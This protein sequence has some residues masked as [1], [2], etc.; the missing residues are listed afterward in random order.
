MA[1]AQRQ[2]AGGFRAADLG[3]GADRDVDGDVGGAGVEQA[4]A[5]GFAEER[6]RDERGALNRITPEATLRGLAAVR[7]RRL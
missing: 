2:V 7:R 5:E 3:G 6:R 1:S 4:R